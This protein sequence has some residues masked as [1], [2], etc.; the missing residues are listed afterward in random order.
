MTPG[1]CP[2]HQ[3][4]FAMSC[5][6]EVRDP[7]VTLV[8]MNRLRVELSDCSQCLHAFDLEVRLKATLATR[9]A[10]QAPEHLST[11]ITE[12]LQRID[13]SSLEITDF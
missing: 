9:L 11:R 10:D 6:A 12:T 13:L 3:C 7:T 8:R 2:P 1:A 5:I 4:E